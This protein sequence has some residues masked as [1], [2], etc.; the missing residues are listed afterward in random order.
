MG[1]LGDD[2]YRPGKP[3]VPAN[4]HRRG[5][6]SADPYVGTRLGTLVPGQR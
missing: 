2:D 5:L 1:I 3:N 4:E 6:T